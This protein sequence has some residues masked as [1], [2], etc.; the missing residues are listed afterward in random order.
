M[1][2]EEI[3]KKLGE[4]AKLNDD[5]A[6]LPQTLLELIKENEKNQESL[7][8]LASSLDKKIAVDYQVGES[9]FRI[10]LGVKQNENN[11]AYLCG[12][13]CDGRIW[14]DGWRARH[15]DIW[16]QEILESKGCYIH[17]I[18]SD[19]WYDNPEGTKSKLLDYLSKISKKQARYQQHN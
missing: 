8:N 9:G 17:R 6:I 19:H 18:W 10:D 12:V 7:K 4:L 2:K 1:D 16:R 5:G 3:K 11:T 13:E 15:N 14:H